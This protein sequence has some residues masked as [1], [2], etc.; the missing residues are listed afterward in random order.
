MAKKTIHL[1]EGTIR[2]IV[3][4]CFKQIIKE[5]VFENGF[6]EDEENNVP[7]KHK[8]GDIMSTSKEE[9]AKGDAKLR[10]AVEKIIKSDA[11]DMAPIAYAVMGGEDGNENKKGSIRS[12][13]RK[14]IYHEEGGNGTPLKL[15]PDETRRSVNALNAQGI[16]V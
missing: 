2:R 16:K 15:S 5:S 4:G 7:R 1:N 6:F 13:F 8:K 11:V 10:D 3:E 14:K 9:N 12:E